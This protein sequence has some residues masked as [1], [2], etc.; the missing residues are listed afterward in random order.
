MNPLP[1]AQTTPAE[2]FD[3]IIEAGRT[4]KHYWRDLWRYRELF[5][6]LAARDVAVRYKQTALGIAWAL[7]QPLLNMLVMTFI[8]GKVAG[9]RSEGETPYALMVFAGMLPWTFCSSAFGSASQ[10][11][12]GSANLISK[13]YFPRIIVPSS[14]IITS[15]VDFLISFLLL[16]AL[17]LWYGYLPG[18]P[19]FTLPLWAGMAFVA[20]LGPGLLITALNVKYR[21]FRYIVPFFVQFGLYLSPVGYSSSVIRE[22]LGN[23]LFML[24]CLN[25]MVGIIDGFRW[26]ILGDN[27]PI[28]LPGFILSFLVSMG[29]LLLGLWYFRKTEKSFADV[30]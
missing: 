8:F 30:I 4:E 1:P 27:A 7:L 14:A 18:W 17:M 10:S 21:D 9:L 20:A 24:Y 23:D 11:L 6:I 19:M 3:L 25:P 12:V 28:Y 13:V 5:I 15:F 16:I 26:A 2:D 22:K 29:F